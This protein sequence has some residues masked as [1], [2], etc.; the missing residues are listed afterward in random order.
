[1]RRRLT[2]LNRQAI[3]PVRPASA[4]HRELIV[5]QECVLASRQ[6]IGRILLRRVEN[7]RTKKQ[8]AENRRVEFVVDAGEEIQQSDNSATSDTADR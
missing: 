5:H 4:L 3:W 2:S 8:H 7:A 6:S 1:M